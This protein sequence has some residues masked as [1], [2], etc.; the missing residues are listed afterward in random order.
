MKSRIAPLRIRNSVVSQFTVWIKVLEKSSLE[1][2]LCIMQLQMGGWWSCCCHRKFADD[3]AGGAN[4]RATPGHPEIAN[5]HRVNERASRSCFNQVCNSLKCS[6]IQPKFSYRFSN[7]I[8]I[9]HQLLSTSPLA[10][11]LGIIG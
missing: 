5:F 11:R 6:L 7:E 8:L 4:Q 1:L 3:R 10:N 9:R 2:V